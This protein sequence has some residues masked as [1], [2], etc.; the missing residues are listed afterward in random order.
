MNKKLLNTME[1][2]KTRVE[3]IV[4]HME[5]IELTKDGIDA[6]GLTHYTSKGTPQLDIDRGIM[7]LKGVMDTLDAAID[8]E[9]KTPEKPYKEQV[10]DLIS[11]RPI[12]GVESIEVNESQRKFVVKY[13]EG[14]Q[15]DAGAAK[16]YMLDRLYAENNLLKP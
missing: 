12:P 7:A 13:K 11:S 2:A 16:A 4:G 3:E 5:R 14:A 1:D 6:S 15:E 10:F 9:K 8:N